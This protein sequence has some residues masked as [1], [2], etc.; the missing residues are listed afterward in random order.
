M[1]L[2]CSSL[3]LIQNIIK[4]HKSNNKSA[5]QHINLGSNSL[6]SLNLQGYDR[7]IGM[8]HSTMK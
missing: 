4:C 8:T 3:F 6:K 2:V 1:H 7:V 5:L